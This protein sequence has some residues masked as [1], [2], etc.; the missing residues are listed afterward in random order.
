[1]EL[2]TVGLTKRYGP[3]TAVDRLSVTLT[4]GVYG[5]LGSNGA[6]KT[7]LMRLICTVQ[8]PTSGKIMLDGEPVR[9]MGEEYRDLLGYL[10]SATTQTLPPWT[11]SSTWRR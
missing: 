7:T 4:S 3:K 10:T 8:E 11:F 5:L 2:K 1:M 6:G 9:E